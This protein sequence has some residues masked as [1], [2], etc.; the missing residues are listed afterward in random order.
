[1]VQRLPLILGAAVLG[2]LVLTMPAE[3]ACSPVLTPAGAARVYDGII[4]GEPARLALI[5][6]KDGSVEGRFA[7]ASST[8]DI[9]MRGKLEPGG[10]RMT[11]TELDKTGHPRAVLSGA[12][13]ETEP[14]PPSAPKAPGAPGYVAIPNR[15]GAI[16]PG[17][18]PLNCSLILGSLQETGG[19]ARELKLRLGHTLEHPS[20][21]HLYAIAGVSD[22][23]V[24]HR[25]AQS[26][27][28]AIAANRRE[29]V[30]KHF[31][32]PIAFTINRQFVVIE[33]EKS[34]LA[35][36]DE[37]FQPAV[38]ERLSH[39]VPRMMQASEA[40]ITLAYGIWLDQEGYIFAY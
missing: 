23:E 5:F 22:D 31:R 11:L 17:P 6:S 14:A 15:E 4:G 38:R 3:A 10:E 9:V 35:R 37:I 13:P 8:S 39:I 33:N 19:P 26:F 20:F 12:F 18:P 36:Y 24:V 1:L 30:V 16:Y 27:R 21:G 32:F 7:L 40:G 29:D 28:N 2:A 25:R 34:L